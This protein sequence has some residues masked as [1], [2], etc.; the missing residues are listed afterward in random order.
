MP[1]K[2]QETRDKEEPR[3]KKQEA[4]EKSSNKIQISTK[5]FAGD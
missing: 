5:G 1:K 2:H 3:Y 4:K